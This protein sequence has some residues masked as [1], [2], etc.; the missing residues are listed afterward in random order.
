[1]QVIVKATRL[2]FGVLSGQDLSDLGKVFMGDR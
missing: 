1:M 2:L